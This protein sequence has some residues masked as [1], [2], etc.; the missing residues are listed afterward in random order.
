MACTGTKRWR[1]PWYRKAAEQGQI[2]AQ[3]NLAVMYGEGL[4][5]PQNSAEAVIW[6]RKAAE[7]GLPDAQ[8]QLGTM[9]G[10]GKGVARDFVEAYLW[11]ELA[12]AQG[13]AEA[14]AQQEV[15][16]LAMTGEQV[17]SAKAR[18]RDWVPCGRE[19]QNRPCP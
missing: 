15:L 2:V 19:P 11:L 14:A 10:A 12:V 8:V 18:A 4:G 6:Y 7:R 3:Y 5:I 1:Q 17:S 16:L 9:I 13:A